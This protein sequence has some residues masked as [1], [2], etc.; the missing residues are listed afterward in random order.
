MLRL[1]NGLMAGA[2]AHVTLLAALG[3]TVGVTGPGWAVGVGCGVVLIAAVAR[4]LARDGA[5][6]LG[7]ADLVTLTRALLAC[8]V[9]ALVAD[10]FLQGTATPALIA[11]TVVA[12][13]LDAVDG[14]VARRTRTASVFG[15]R[16]DG[17]A[18]AFL[19]LVLSVYVA[20]SLGAWVLAI[21]AAR[22]VFALAG[23]G[24]PWL[25]GQLPFRYW[26]KVV[27]ATAGTALAVAAAD[28]AP[29]WMTYA[30]LAL[31][32]G[33]LTESFGRDVWWLWRHRSAASVEVAPPVAP[34]TPE[35]AATVAEAGP[36]PRA[37]RRRAVGAAMT[38]AL[39]LLLV[40]FALVVPNQLHGLTPS[41]FLRI[42]VEGLALAG[43]ALVLGAR[44]RAVMA[45]VV[46]A[47]LGLLTVLKF[48]DMGSFAAFDRP[49]DLV[50]D[51]GYLF[52]AVGLARDLVGPVGAAVA[53]VA[54]IGLVVAVLVCVPLSLHRLTAV[55][56]RHR[57]WSVRAVAGLVVLWTACAMSGLQLGQ[58]APIASAS[59]GGFAAGQVRAI[60]DGVGDQ[61]RFDA[62][63]AVDRYRDADGRH[64]LAELR[65]K[66]V[67]VT[68]V[69][70]YGRVALEGLPTSGEVRSVLDA[71][72]TRLQAAGYSSRSAFLTSPTFGG[73]SWLAHSTLQS[74]LWVDNERHYDDLLSANRMTLTRA[75]G[76]EGWRTVAVM[77]SNKEAW[78]EGRHFYRF[79]KVYGGWE[80]GYLGPRFGFS[81]MP[82]QFVLSAFQRL[83]LARHGRTPVMAEI[84][85]ASSHTPWAPLPGLVDWD[86][87]GDGSVFGAIKERATSAQD[88]WLD[89]ADIK[90]AYTDS[91][92]YCLATLI[93]YVETYGDDD[94]VLIVLGDHQPAS[95]VSG[96]AT[97]HD[98]PITVI[99][100]DPTIIDHI[101]GWG[102]QDGLR[103]D[104]QAPVWPMDAF[105]DRFIAAYSPSL[106]ALGAS[107][108]SPP[109]QP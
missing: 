57:R 104:H 64:L 56:A 28:V 1:R 99:A 51:R 79:D 5:D 71:G 77:P 89:T 39:A 67:L 43:L 103:P 102:W 6:V 44:A 47:L 74:G 22:Y 73:L 15:A 24:L 21:G 95:I 93:S 38:N 76:R 96:H 109:T 16:F 88:V 27:A 92:A 58:G 50:N 83:E 70:S 34:I 26:R 7:P 33:L 105:R 37:G 35:K 10:S 82:D 32:L 40:W 42:P 14:W 97:S 52:S 75:F 107:P 18:D 20:R 61:R 69:E 49:F 90:A 84:D 9:A 36:P 4:G 55:V 63:V 98:V 62:A 45:V 8:S 72:T 80:L 59:A 17:E 11:L 23:W 3:A 54:A 41:A 101:S 68:F 66:D 94:L 12:L 31:A 81:S 25:R 30:A 13:S 46:G 91:I 108:D 29:R 53:V 86:D 78:P 48:F 65:G 87:L 2:T 100:R 60:T 19:I 106:S 85:L